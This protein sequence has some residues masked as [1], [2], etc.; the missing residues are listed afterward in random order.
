MRY[1]MLG[2]LLLLS[3]LSALADSVSGQI[4]VSLTIV[5]GCKIVVLAN[6]PQISCANGA[7]SQPHISES[8]LAFS[9][10]LVTIEW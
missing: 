2:A 5:P 7:L 10:K 9:T 8:L 1:A 6:H 3:P 4:S